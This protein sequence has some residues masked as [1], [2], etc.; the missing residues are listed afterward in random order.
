MLQNT[1]RLQQLRTGENAI[2]KSAKEKH[3]LIMSIGRQHS[4]DGKLNTLFVCCKCIHEQSCSCTQWSNKSTTNK[5][6][7]QVNI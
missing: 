1:L 7:E 6:N 3:L 5:Y 2:V 4:F